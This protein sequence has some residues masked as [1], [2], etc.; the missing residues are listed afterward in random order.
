VKIK[1]FYAFILVFFGWYVFSSALPLIDSRMIGM[2]VKLYTLCIILLGFFLA[3][4]WIKFFTNKLTILVVVWAVYIFFV[5]FLVVDSGQYGYLDTFIDTTMWISVFFTFYFVFYND[6]KG[7]YLLK[8]LTIYPYFYAI[9]FV[10]VTCRMYYSIDQSLVQL[11]QSDEINSVYWVLVMTPLA[12]LMKSKIT[13]YAIIVS[14]FF[15]ILLS[16]KRLGAIAIFSILVGSVAMDAKSSGYGLGKLFI[17][18]LLLCV[19]LFV[20]QVI[21]DKDE[22]NVIQR[23]SATDLREESRVVLYTDTMITYFSKDPIS[24]FIGSG[25]RSTGRDRGLDMVTKTAHN[26]FIEVLYNYGVIGLV[27]YMSILYTLFS[28]LRKVWL[29]NLNAYAAYASCLVLFIAM[30][31]VSHLVIYPSYFTFLV[32]MFALFEA[33]LVKLRI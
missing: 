3:L 21:A 19:P 22:V 17:G 8:M 32:L 29:I 10:I 27:I 28:R 20:F 12:F 30:S 14:A 31:M 7:V 1:I 24:Q 5:N 4:T 23:L 33:K 25:H 6:D 26:D 2:L 18:L 9:V 15:L 13:R 16:T 11:H